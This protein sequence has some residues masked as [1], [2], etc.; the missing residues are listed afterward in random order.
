MKQS[1]HVKKVHIFRLNLVAC[2]H[3]RFQSLIKTRWD[4]LQI[5]STFDNQ[6]SNT[7]AYWAVGLLAVHFVRFPNY[8]IPPYSRCF[9]GHNKKHTGLEPKINIKNKKKNIER[10]SN[11]LPAVV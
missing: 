8:Y 3:A 4:A 11:I 1:L 10:E 9:L 2:N 5:V 6:W 7:D